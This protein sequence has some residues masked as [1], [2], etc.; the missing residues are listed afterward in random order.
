MRLP[1]V[2]ACFPLRVLIEVCGENRSGCTVILVDPDWPEVVMLE[3]R[4]EQVEVGYT[5]AKSW[6][7]VERRVVDVVCR[8]FAAIEPEI[9][10]RR[11]VY[12]LFG[13][14]FPRLWMLRTVARMEPEVDARTREAEVCG[15]EGSAGRGKMSM[16][17]V[18]AIVVIDKRSK[19]G[20]VP[21][22]EPDAE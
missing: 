17:I 11:D 16:S 13:I 15:V 1:L 6:P 12:I 7:E 14:L 19:S 3:D 22:M 4:E 21:E 8:S 20:Y 18:P 2:F 9:V 10:L 5:S